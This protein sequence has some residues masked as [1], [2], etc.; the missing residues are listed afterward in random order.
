MT[1]G[2]LH[3]D[4]NGAVRPADGAAAPTATATTGRAALATRPRD[5]DTRG[6]RGRSSPAGRA[7]R[8]CCPR[9]TAEDFRRLPIA[10]QVIQVQPDRG[11]VLVNKETIVLTDP[12]EQTFRT[13]LFGYGVDVIATPTHYTWDFQDGSR[14][15]VHRQPR[16]A[17]PGL[18]R[19]P[20]LHRSRHRGG[21]ADHHLV[22][23]VPGRRRRHLARRRRHRRDHQHVGG[24]RDRRAP[25][26]PGR[27]GLHPGPRPA[28][29]R[30]SGQALSES[31]SARPASIALYS[32]SSTSP[33]R[34]TWRSRRRAVRSS[35]R[36]QASATTRSPSR[37][38][39]SR[40]CPR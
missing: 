38:S 17:V 30:L 10:P 11:W 27:P 37:G 34:S 33:S 36:D 23:P 40:R 25:L 24:V 14:A 28:R 19:L 9:F 12:A 22:G 39:G 3:T 13:D 29:L 8:T 15:P 1:S 4:I 26:A 16:H 6:D 2:T 21:H 18:R 35:S 20:R 31:R 5:A 7:P 32:S